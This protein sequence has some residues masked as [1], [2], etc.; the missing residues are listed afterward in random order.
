MRWFER[1]DAMG[2]GDMKPMDPD[3]A[4]KIAKESTPAASGHSDAGDPNG[5][6]LGARVA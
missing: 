3:E 2:A 1:L 4:L 5:L 6:Q